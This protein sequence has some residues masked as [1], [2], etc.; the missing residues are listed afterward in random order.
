MRTSL[1]ELEKLDSNK[2]FTF[3]L[4][5]RIVRVCDCRLL[6]IEFD[7]GI[8]KGKPYENYMEPVKVSCCVIDRI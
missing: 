4:L 7:R 6:Y 1:S 5:S 3:R 2:G 8:L